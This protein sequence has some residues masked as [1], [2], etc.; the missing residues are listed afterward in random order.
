MDDEINFK[1][2]NTVTNLKLKAIDNHEIKSFD[3]EHDLKIKIKNEKVYVKTI[4]V[5]NNGEEV[6]LPI[7]S[8]VDLPV[9]EYNLEL[10]VETLKDRAVYP[11]DGFLKLNINGS[12]NQ[13]TGDLFSSLTLADLEKEIEDALKLANRKKIGESIGSTGGISQISVSDKGTLVIDGKDTGTVIRGDKGEPG[14]DGSPGKDGHDGAKGEPGRN[15]KSA[16]E[17]AVD[18][19]FIGSEIEWLESLKGH[20]G[21]PGRD[22]VKGDK[23]EQGERG[24]DGAPGANGKSAYELAIENGFIGTQTEWIKSLNGRD[25][26]PGET[27][28]K[29]DKGEP[30]RDGKS[31]YEIALANGFNGSQLDWVNSLKGKDGIPGQKGKDGRDGVKGDKGE[32]GKTPYINADGIWCIGEQNT[33]VHAGVTDIKKI[34]SSGNLN[35]IRKSGSYD[36]QGILE[37]SPTKIDEHWSTLY[38]E[39]YN[40]RVVIQTLINDTEFN[41]WVRYYSDNNWSSW[42]W[43]SVSKLENHYSPE[44]KSFSVNKALYAPFENCVF[45]AVTQS[46]SGVL[47]IKYWKRNELITTQHVSYT[48][49]IVSWDWQLPGDDNESYIAQI[50]NYVKDSQ[51][52]YYYAI[53]VDTNVD[54]LPIMG[55]ISTFSDDNP[56]KRSE[57]L[58]YLKRLH[59]NY[60]QYYDWMDRH[61]TPLPTINSSSSPDATFIPNTWSDI[62]NRLIRKRVIEKY[63]DQAKEFGMRNMAYMAINGSDTTEEVHGLKPDM[64]LYND[65]KHDLN[66]VYK[67]LD[68]NNG[69]GKYSLYNANWMNE[70]WQNYMYDQMLITIC[71]LPFEGWHID[72]LGSP[73]DK[74][75]VNGNLLPASFLEKGIT[76]FINKQSELGIPLGINSVAEYGIKQI[77]ESEHLNYLYTEVWDRP[78]YNDLRDLI[79]SLTTARDSKGRKKGVIIAG[80]MDYEYSKGHSGG[81]FNDWGVVITDLLIMSLGAVHLEMGEHMLSNEYFPNSNL[82]MSD[83]LKDKLI[84]IS[85]F[86]IAYKKILV[87]GYECDGLATIENGSVDNVEIGK[88]NGITKK[89]DDD[90]LGIS[91]IN[92]VGLNHDK[93]KDTNADQSQ[94]IPQENV[95]VNIELGATNHTWYYVDLDNLV[96][97]KIELSVNNGLIIPKLVDYGFVF[98]VKKDN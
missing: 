13:L 50:T 78:T 1:F 56:N 88:V 67:T 72:M 83:S 29:G 42:E 97:K 10:W 18:E 60:L 43:V 32:N 48:Q 36:I 70:N 11:D 7:N 34:I 52:T 66:N 31:A 39:N 74:Y 15:G 30:G 98:G 79:I 3:E 20:D 25:G 61:S 76:Y 62:G 55:F 91:L 27:G 94:P 21:K 75:D 22:G 14:R 80:Y 87:D 63:I 37:N 69:W 9:G 53:N 85:D 93:W 44:L 68:A 64:W 16:Y 90:I 46:D 38:V 19:G 96:P 24:Q 17:L 89:N 95:K 82:N 86:L 65:N 4:N 71:N 57:V 35:E 84:K 5:T 40:N 6:L 12:A 49:H 59:V 92:M 47:E 58:D 54:N 51:K 26:K 28:S 45:S 23:G 41:K 73:G 77:K 8:L 33:G 2:G 81:Y